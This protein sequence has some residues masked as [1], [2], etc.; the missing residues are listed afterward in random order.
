MPKREHLP[1]CP[2]RRTR[3]EQAWED[4]KTWGFIVVVFVGW[5]L[6]LGGFREWAAL[7]WR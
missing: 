1:T 2:V 3:W 4:I 7:I 6:L 5:M